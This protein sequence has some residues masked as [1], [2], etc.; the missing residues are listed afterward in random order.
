MER[1]PARSH[2]GAYAPHGP[3]DASPSLGPRL[4]PQCDPRTARVAHFPFVH[5]LRRSFDTQSAFKSEYL[6]MAPETGMPV[7]AGRE[8]EIA[9]KHFEIVKLD[10]RPVDEEL[11]MAIRRLCGG[12]ADAMNK[13]YAFGS[14]FSEEL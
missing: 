9:G 14:V 1:R 3:T 12:V 5:P 4:S 7:K 8:F 10:D 11:R 6:D 13:Y 2:S